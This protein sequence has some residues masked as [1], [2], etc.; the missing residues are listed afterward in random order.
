MISVIGNIKVDE[1]K[2]ERVSYLLATIRSY[3]FLQD[4]AEIILLL[5][6]PSDDLYN[7]VLPE[8]ERTSCSWRLYSTTIDAEFDNLS[9]GQQYCKLLDKA[10]YDHVLNF[11]EDQFMVLN[12]PLRLIS[13]IAKM[14]QDNVDVCKSSFHKVEMNSARGL[15]AI[16]RDSI[17]ESV[18]ISFANDAN[19]FDQY[20]KY[21]G[22]RYYIGVNFLTTK[23]FAYKFW[24][25]N[26]GCRPHEYE[27]GSF[28][29]QWMHVSMIPG[30]G[31]ELQA[32]IDDDHGEEGT[33]MLKRDHTKFWQLYNPEVTA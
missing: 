21:Y 24:N 25:R 31:F 19:N 12:E 17:S 16:P 23:R 22:K 29:A 18:G 28:S 4:W 9:Y 15:R 32:P 20:Q 8:L 13:L 6:S 2:P 1:T 10:E 30:I 26:Q 33:C 7:L 5:Q 14:E 11:M 3:A 27:I